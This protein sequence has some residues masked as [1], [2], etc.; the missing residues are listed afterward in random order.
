[1]SLR[2]LLER[3][4][5]EK[6][7]LDMSGYEPGMRSKE[8]DAQVRDALGGHDIRPGAHKMQLRPEEEA[9]LELVPH[10]ACAL[11]LPCAHACSC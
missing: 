1:M 6:A 4:A 3:Y 10:P 11:L 9:L 5:K 7:I 8:D 2:K